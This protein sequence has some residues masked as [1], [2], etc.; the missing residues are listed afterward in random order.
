MYD[1]FVNRCESVNCEQH[2]IASGRYKF[3]Q[4]YSD[5]SCWNLERLKIF[6]KDQENTNT[7]RIHLIITRKSDFYKRLLWKVSLENSNYLLIHKLFGLSS[8]FEPFIYRSSRYQAFFKLAALKKLVKFTRKHL[9]WS[10]SF[11]YVAVFRRNFSK[12]FS[13][14]LLEYMR[15]VLPTSTKYIKFLLWL[16]ATEIIWNQ[17]KIWTLSEII[18]IINNFFSLL[19]LIKFF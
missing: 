12:F 5:N 19:L 16:K 1:L 3:K 7:I 9:C 11:N 4:I 6:Q 2:L 8:L 13:L 15:T 17:L 18:W 14:V 10:L